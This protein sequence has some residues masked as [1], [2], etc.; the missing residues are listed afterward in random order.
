MCLVFKMGFRIWRVRRDGRERYFSLD[1]WV[2][3]LKSKGIDVEGLFWANVRRVS[4]C[5]FLLVC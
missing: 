5:V 4:F 1:G 3:G 2:A